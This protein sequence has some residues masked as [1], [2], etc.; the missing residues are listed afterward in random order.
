MLWQSEGVEIIDFKLTSIYSGVHFYKFTFNKNS[1]NNDFVI[2]LR[3]NVT[4]HL[5]FPKL[6]KFEFRLRMWHTLRY[7]YQYYVILDNPTDSIFR[8]DTWCIIYHSLFLWK[9][10]FKK[11]NFFY[12]K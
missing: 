7:N 9:L 3:K 5:V 6:F 4:I 12:K 8:R 11:L 2:N 10:D 1:V